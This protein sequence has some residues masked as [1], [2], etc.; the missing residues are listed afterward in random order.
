MTRI[1]VAGAAGKMGRTLIQTIVNSEGLEVTAALEREGL[2]VI[3]ADAGEVAGVGKLNIPI[4]DRL[5]SV[6]DDF[7]ILIDFTVAAATVENMEACADFGR[8]MIIGTTGLSEK[9]KARLG[10]LASTIAVVH[11]SNF[12]IGVNAT[13]RLLEVA[14]QIFGD[15]VDVEI[16]ESHH[17]HKIDA[18]SG[19]AL[20]MGEI[21]A[22]S[23]G[24]DLQ[25]V[26]VYGREGITGERSREAIGFHS[27][28]AGDIVGE[29]TVVFAGAGER[30]EITHRAQSR[31]N[32][33]EGAVRAAIWIAGQEKG[34]FD[35]RDVLGLRD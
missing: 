15:T 17:R 32:F 6:C 24:R 7:D 25:E 29:H 4:T 16:I 14:G 9:D 11:A 21:I 19:T 10:D 28:R 1:A 18:P 27:M 13:F 35:M 12:S 26:A 33:A 30:L 3:G 20:T 31:A 34:L 23:L 2:S 8:K 22:D 5:E